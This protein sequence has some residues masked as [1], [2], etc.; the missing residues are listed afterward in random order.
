[1][2]FLDVVDFSRCGRRARAGESAENADTCRQENEEGADIRR[3]E[4]AGSRDSRRQQTSAAR[5]EKGA[6]GAFLLRVG[7]DQT[8]AE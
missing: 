4:N 3:E 6:D 2:L 8:R 7:A 1:M 5:G